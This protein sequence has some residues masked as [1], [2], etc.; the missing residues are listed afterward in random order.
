MSTQPFFTLLKGAQVLSPENLGVQDI[1]IAGNKIAAI[2]VSLNKPEGYECEVIDLAKMTLMPG[3]IDSHVHLIGGGG[4]GGFSTRTPE[5]LLSKI[6]TC[7]VTTV[8]GCLGT[9]GTTRHVESLLAKARGLEEEGVSTYIYTGAYELPTPTITGSVRRDI[10]MMDKIIGAGEIAMSDH[11]SAQPTKTDYQK[12]AAEARIGGMLSG[13]AGIVDMHMGDGRDGLNLLFAITENGEIPKTQFLPT[14][15][16]R[17]RE[18]FKQSLDWAKQGGYMDITSG[19]SP[20]SE[21]DRVIKPSTAVKKALDAGVPL[22]RITMSSDGN[23]SMPIFD[24]KGNTIGVGVASQDSLLKEVCDMVQQ[25]GIALETAIQTVTSN[26]AKALK[27]WPAKG[28][29]SVGADA[30]FLIL[31]EKLGM[32]HVFAKGRQMVKSGKAIVHGTFE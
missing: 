5:V 12:L 1:L 20:T 10:I 29:V 32:Q 31:D 14:H 9:D 4:E 8:V 23:G 27:I 2:G 30:D 16:N 18:L 15:V 17:N 6:T 3:L 19:I 28:S 25:E 22:D 11:R 13:K 24:E 21:E 7:G 26:V